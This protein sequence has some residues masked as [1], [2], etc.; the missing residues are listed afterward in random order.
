MTAA[1]AALDVVF[2]RF[3][4]SVRGAVIVRGL[5][6]DPHQVA[7]SEIAAVEAADPS[8]LRTA[9]DL[10][11]VSVD[12]IP[13]G[14][15]VVP[16]DVPFA[17]L[18][19]GWYRIEVEG[20]VDGQWRVR[21]PVDH[22]TFVVPWPAEDVRRGHVTVGRSVGGAEIERVESRS[23]RSIV[24][25]RAEG[26]A[27]LRI[28]VGRHRLPLIERPD[29]STGER[30]TIAY[31]LLKRYTSLTLEVDRGRERSATIIELP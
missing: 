25:W 23:D 4:A 6:A 16:F 17:S 18:E 21:G 30:T 26:D 10:E 2:E 19:P 8:R 13:R 15:V 27:D 31:P 11:P 29:P 20:L 28:V 12:V 3:P 1:P 9:L 22:K 5:D 7:I 14:E 24:R